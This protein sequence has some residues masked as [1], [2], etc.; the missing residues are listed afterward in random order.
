MKYNRH[1]WLEHYR[2]FLEF[3]FAQVF[4]EPHSTKQIEDCVGWGL[5][6]T[7]ETLIA[8]DAGLGLDEEADVRKL[9]ARIRCPVL[10]VHGS[11]DAIRS[12]SSGAAAAELLGGML[13]TLDGSGH[14]PFARDPVKV[15]LLLRDF[16]TRPGS[17]AGMDASP[18]AGPA[19]PLRVIADRPWPRPPR[20]RDR[21][22]APPLGSGPEDRLA[23][24]ATGHDDP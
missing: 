8:T 12:H 1:Y 11:E 17:A 24:P 14:A 21:R 15:N 19:R 10:V 16:V 2:D 3:F 23:G 4:T 5:E 20:R 7:P 6:T 18:G 22:R 9:A 13:L